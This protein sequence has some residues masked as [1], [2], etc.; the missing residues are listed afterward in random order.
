[1][2]KDSAKDRKT[3]LFPG[4]V[5]K[6]NMTFEQAKTLASPV[7]AL[8]FWNLSPFEPK[9]STDVAREIGKSSQ[10]VRF[11]L[12]ALLEHGLILQVGERKRRSRTEQLLVRKARGTFD[13]GPRGNEAYN[14]VMTRAFKLETMK[15]VRETSHHN[16]W[17]EHDPSTHDFAM[18]R[19]FHMRLSAEQAVALRANIAKLLVEAYENQVPEE[20]G[21]VQVNAVAMIRPTLHQIRTWAEKAGIDWTTL[22]REGGSESAEDGD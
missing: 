17:M 4:Q 2:S 15:M 5:E 22:D 6:L 13:Q 9:S 21:G 8:V 11:H 19:K 12:N 16:G 20:E 18:F 14:R 10:A 7:R 3:E 1:M